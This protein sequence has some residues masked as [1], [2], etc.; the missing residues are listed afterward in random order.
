MELPDYVIPAC[1]L[2]YGYPVDAQKNRKKP[3][4]FKN[5]YI[6]SENKY[7]RLSYE[8][9]M[10]MHRA[11]NEDSGIKGKSI[12]EQVQAFCERKYM[13]EFAYEMNRSASSYLEKFRNK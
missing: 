11:K 5:Q 8:E 9:H 13:S 3:V 10:E 6:V 7:R 4:R 2:V 1:M 12:T